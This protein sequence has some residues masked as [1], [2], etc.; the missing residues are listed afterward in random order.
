MDGMPVSDGMPNIH[1]CFST[2]A[3]TAPLIQEIAYFCIRQV[4]FRDYW[5]GIDVA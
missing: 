5:I 2:P 1:M 4:G 3:Y